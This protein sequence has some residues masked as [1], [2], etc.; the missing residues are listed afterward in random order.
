VLPSHS[1]LFPFPAVLLAS[2][3]SLPAFALLIRLSKVL[4]YLIV[5]KPN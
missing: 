3:I 2:S 4:E 5:M 1:S